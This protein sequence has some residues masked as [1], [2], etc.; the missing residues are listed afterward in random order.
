VNGPTIKESMSGGSTHES[1]RGGGTHGA[2]RT[3]YI[4]RG[5]G[6]PLHTLLHLSLLLLFHHS[7]SRLEKPCSNDYPPSPRRRDAG[8]SLWIFYFRYLTGSRERRS[9]LIRTCDQVRK[10]CLFVVLIFTILRSASVRLHHPR[11][12]ISLTL[13]FFEGESF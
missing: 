9:S 11:D 3:P 13:S 12:L 10:R 4:L 1:G 8:V 2:C 7:A 6:S 5:G